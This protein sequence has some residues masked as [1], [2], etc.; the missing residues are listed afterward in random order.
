ML[1]GLIYFVKAHMWDCPHM[2]VQPGSHFF[3]VANGMDNMSFVQFFFWKNKLRIVLFAH[4]LA[5]IVPEKLE[6]N[7]FYP[8][9]NFPTH[10]DPR[11]LWN[12][13]KPIYGIK[14]T[15]ISSQKPKSTWNKKIK[16]SSNMFSHK[17]KRFEK[18]LI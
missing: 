3:W 8:K 16:L 6:L 14:K 11:H 17:L 7:L 15:K 5:I 9:I 10:F 1:L 13:Y 2:H 12:H 4:I 18:H